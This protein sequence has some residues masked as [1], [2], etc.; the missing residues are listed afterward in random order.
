MAEESAD[1]LHH[2]KMLLDMLFDLTRADSSRSVPPPV[3]PS[4]KQ[5]GWSKW[6]EQIVRG[7]YSAASGAAITVNRP[8]LC[9]AD[10]HF[11]HG[12]SARAARWTGRARFMSTTLNAAQ[13]TAVRIR[14]LVSAGVTILA[15]WYERH[16]HH[17][18]Q[19]ACA[20]RS[21]SRARR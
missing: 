3:R 13:S 18:G 12:P 19:R 4:P 20:G 14:S 7:M 9:A 6:R 16:I 17:G 2:D 21:G 5:H 11:T 1:R 15:V 8:A 10:T